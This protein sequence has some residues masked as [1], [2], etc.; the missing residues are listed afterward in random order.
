MVWSRANSQSYAAA[1]MRDT[2]NRSALSN[3]GAISDAQCTSDCVVKS[4]RNSGYC[5]SACRFDAGKQPLPAQVGW[6]AHAPYHPE[7]HSLR[8]LATRSAPVP[9]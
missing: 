6:R 9:L 1:R 4:G 2:Q 3:I 5:A 7:T 8:S